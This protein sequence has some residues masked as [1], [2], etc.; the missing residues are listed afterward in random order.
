MVFAGKAAFQLHNRPYPHLSPP[1]SK[2][3]IPLE[4]CKRDH[5]HY[6]CHNRQYACTRLIGFGAHAGSLKT[7]PGRT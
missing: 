4:R 7:Q 5:K 2:R 1:D 6:I 3:K